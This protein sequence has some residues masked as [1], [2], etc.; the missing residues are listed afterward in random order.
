M[1]RN[2]RIFKVIL[3][4]ALVIFALPNS[5]NAG[6][7]SNYVQ[8]YSN[9]GDCPTCNLF[10]AGNP[11]IQKYFVT[12]NNGWEAELLWTHGDDSTAAGSGRWND[13]AGPALAGRGFEIDLNQQGRTLS[14]VMSYPGGSGNAP[15]RATFSCL[16]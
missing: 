16:D 13:N 2:H 15:I 10:I 6:F 8:T 5:A 1:S 14:M 7:C 12:S 3:T 9:A 11:G 4:S